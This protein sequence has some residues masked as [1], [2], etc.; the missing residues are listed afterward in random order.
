MN[1][2]II[3]IYKNKFCSKRPLQQVDPISSI[4]DT[5]LMNEKPIRDS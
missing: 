1:Y 3:K 2:S 4:L 5:T